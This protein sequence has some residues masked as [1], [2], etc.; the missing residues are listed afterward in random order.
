MKKIILINVAVLICL[1]VSLEIITRI[2]ISATRGSS[3]AGLIERSLNL[4][5]QPFVM[6]GPDWSEIYNNFN[7]ELNKNNGNLVI[8]LIGGSTAQG[9]PNE[10][11]EQKISKKLNKKIK[12]FNSA[13]GGYIS[14]QELILTTIYSKRI[15]PD[16][17]INLNTAND[18]IHSLRKNNKSGT[19]FLNNTYQNILTRPFLAPFIY[20]LQ[21]SQLFNGLIRLKA[22]NE[23]FNSQDYTKHIDVF[24]ENINNIYLYC[25]A[26][27][28]GYLNVM[29]PHVIFKNLQHESEK[30]F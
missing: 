3:T 7:Q 26:A 22:R 17:I 15:N 28:I 29:Q 5:Y 9:F 25:E 23:N 10:I 20:L 13:Y 30:K 12:V 24:I 11:L 16:I 8:L 6:Y 14:T 21:H 19:F 2:Y 27:D 18:I 4:K 1:L